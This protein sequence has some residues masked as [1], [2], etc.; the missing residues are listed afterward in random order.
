[1]KLQVFTPLYKG[2]K[3]TLQLA[4]TSKESLLKLDNHQWFVVWFSYCPM[5]EQFKILSLNIEIPA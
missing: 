5:R 4:I 1:L 2:L 3:E